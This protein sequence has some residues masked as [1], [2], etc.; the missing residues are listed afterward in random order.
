MSKVSLPKGGPPDVLETCSPAPALRRLSRYRVG[1]APRGHTVAAQSRA[2]RPTWE[3]LA[4][5]EPQRV[6]SCSPPF[7]Q[8]RSRHPGRE[9]R[10]A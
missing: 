7:C 9:N 10:W 4:E 2:P 3:A 5:A 8:D 1:A 6:A